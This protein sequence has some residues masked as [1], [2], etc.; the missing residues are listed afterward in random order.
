MVLRATLHIGQYGL[1]ATAFSIHSR[2]NMCL[3]LVI[4]GPLKSSKQMTHLSP[5]NTTLQLI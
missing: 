4:T 1:A 5:T 2:Q 3:H